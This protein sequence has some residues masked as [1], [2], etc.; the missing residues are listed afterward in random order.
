MK[1]RC[2]GLMLAA[3]ILGSLVNCSSTRDPIGA[4]PP[5]D[6][7]SP[8]SPPTIE[9]E[10]CVDAVAETKRAADIIVTIDQSGSMGEEVTQLESTI[11]L[12]SSMLSE[13]DLDYRVVMLA[14]TG[15][16]G[17]LV[18]VPPPLGGE[19]CGSNGTIY[20]AV[21]FSIDSSNALS[22]ILHT[23]D[24]PTE[25]LAWRDFLRPN[26]LKVF[27]PITDDD[28]SMSATVFDGAL[29]R[30]DDGLFGVANDRN[31]TFFPVI[32]ANDFPDTSECPTADT[33]GREYQKLVHLTS[34]RWFSVCRP[35]LRPMLEAI[36]RA[37][38]A[39]TACEVAIPEPPEGATLDLG[40][41]NVR[42]VPPNGSPISV[43]QDTTRPC[44]DGADGWQFSGDEK[45][46]VL[47]GQSCELAQGDLSHRLTV[48]FGC[49]TITR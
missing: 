5:S 2:I 38:I 18:C 20:R 7:G 43:L 17:G 37:T 4:P 40:K 27:A 31:Y 46:I 8:S 41:I 35:S 33:A 15:R 34:G 28:S 22:A 47:C 1:T 32:G 19:D 26:V 44:A 9:Q 16:G 13:S 21:N 11:N 25:S 39:R 29:L 49:E 30:R 14:E 48:G 23:L 42:L 12:L 45:R 3:V 24:T 10:T 36:G 6:L